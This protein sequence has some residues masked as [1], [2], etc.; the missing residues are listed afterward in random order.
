MIKSPLD[1]YQRIEKVGEGTY[2]VVY[3][4]RIVATGEIV[5][6]KKIRLETQEEG[7]PSTAIREVAALTE[8]DHPNIVRLLDIIH[9]GNDLYLV[10]EYLEQDLKKY[11]DKLKEL[12]TPFLSA[13]LVRSYLKQ[14][15]SGILYCHS[16]R[17]MHRDL[18]P[19]NLLVDRSGNIKICDFGL[20]RMYSIPMRSYTH[21]IVTLWYRP[22]EVLL[23]SKLYSLPVDVW[24]IGCIFAEMSNG[25]P[26]FKGDSEIDQLYHIFQI[27]GTPNE[28]MWPGVSQLPD[29]RPVFPQWRPKNLA[30]LCPNLSPNG[31]D[32][33]RKMLTYDP[34]KRISV[35][36]ALSHPYFSE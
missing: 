8:L 11:M 18:K 28:T 30:E 7:V 27:C 31:I 13:N 22:P 6:L 4:A 21:E 5:A 3:K 2:G 12:G 10:F 17:M 29:W 14:L 19:Q 32:L 24:G 20:A 25:K 1:K 33:L 35:K 9:Q 36:E 16:R 26:F 34:A 23:G 15:L